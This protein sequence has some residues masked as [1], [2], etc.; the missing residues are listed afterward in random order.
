M[1]KGIKY[2]LAF[3]VG[4]A[5]GS[6]TAWKLLKTKYE[7]LTQFEVES[8]RDVYAKRTERFRK[9]EEAYF[10]TLEAHGLSIDDPVEVEVEEVDNEDDDDDDSEYFVYEHAVKQFGYT[11]QVDEEKKGGSESVENDRPY[12]ITPE[13]FAELED[14]DTISLIYYADGVLAD[15]QDE[16]IDNVDEIVG[17]ESLITFGEYEDDSV[18]VRNDRLKAD[19][20]ILLDARRYVDVKK[21]IPNQADEG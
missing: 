1:N 19:Y 2:L 5:A 12:V 4:A 9:L 7:T 10:A 17:A 14:Y 11:A 8:V 6:I 20:E 16:V 3:A 13:D 21:S 18:F 15:D